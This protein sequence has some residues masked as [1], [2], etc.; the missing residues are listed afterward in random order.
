MINLNGE[1]KITK[2]MEKELIIAINNKSPSPSE[3]NNLL[4]QYQN[5]QYGNT[6]KLA[7]SITE[8]FP[9]HQF[10]WKVLGAVIKQTGRISESLLASQKSVELKPL[11]SEA[12]NNLSVT[13]IELGRLDEAEVS[14]KQAIA[15]NPDYAEAHN[16]LGVTLKELGRLDE[17]IDSYKKALSIK[18]E[19]TEVWNNIFFPLQAIKMHIS[20]P[21]KFLFDFFNE[22]KSKSEEIAKYILNYKLN[23]GEGISNTLL[24]EVIDVISKTKNITIKNPEINKKSSSLDHVLPEKIIALIH[25]GRSGTGLLHSLIDG[26]TEVSTL[27]SIYL[28]DYFDHSTWNKITANGWHGMADCFIA[29]YEVLFDATSTVSIETQGKKMLNKI[30]YKEGMTTV[31][32]NQDEALTLDKTL[33]RKEL[34]HLMESEKILDAFIFFKLIHLAYERAIKNH[35]QKNLIF[36]YIHNRFLIQ[37]FQY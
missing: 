26:H 14:L 17:A 16:N 37:I 27:P 3:L 9:E 30:G 12:H 23:R 1:I 4:E 22:T 31:G 35:N 25:F 8:R 11:D 7:L 21:D 24:T 32:N 2:Q 13:L 5:G 20:S 6:E 10:A 15:L 28:S 33:F 18:P 36:Y 19:Y 34:I 29:T